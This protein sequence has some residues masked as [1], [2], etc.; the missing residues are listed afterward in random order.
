VKIRRVGHGCCGDITARLS[1]M[2]SAG[3]KSY[4]YLLFCELDCG[5]L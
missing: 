4:S 1:R 5:A 3:I 2:E